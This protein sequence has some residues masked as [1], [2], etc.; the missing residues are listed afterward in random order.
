M[1]DACLAIN[2]KE[3]ITEQVDNKH[4]MSGEGLIADG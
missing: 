1:F 4:V 3:P 2:V